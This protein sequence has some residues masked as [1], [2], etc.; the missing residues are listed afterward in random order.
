MNRQNLKYVRLAME[1]LMVT[2]ISVMNV[3]FL[4]AIVVLF[5]VILL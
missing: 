3:E 1:R 5:M 2:F 4:F